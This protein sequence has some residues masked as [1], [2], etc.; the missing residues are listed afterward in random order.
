MYLSGQAPK[1]LLCK[2]VDWVLWSFFP[3]TC[4]YRCSSMT[5]SRLEISCK[6]AS[7]HY[8]C[9][10]IAALMLSTPNSKVTLLIGYLVSGGGSETRRLGGRLFAC[11]LLVLSQRLM[12]SR[13]GIA[14]Q[15]IPL[16]TSK[17]LVNNCRIP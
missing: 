15:H 14:L 16:P 5:L 13:E 7:S 10:L 11:C 9:L 4:W 17:R 12:Q 6:A 1:S 3:E 2:F 8:W